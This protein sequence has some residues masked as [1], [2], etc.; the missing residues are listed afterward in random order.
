MITR[1]HIIMGTLGAAAAIA[2]ILTQTAGS[3]RQYQLGGAWIGNNGAGNIWS[4]SHAPLDPEGRTMVGSIRFAT[5]NADFA[6]ILSSLGADTS[7]DHIGQAEMISRD[8]AKWSSVSY[9]LKAGNPPVLQ[10]ILV[11]QGTWKYTSKDTAVLTYTFYAYLP[12]ADADGDGFPDAGSTPAIV[13][14][15]VVDTAQRVPLPCLHK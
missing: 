15:G 2:F 6:A 14:P 7:S 8:T 13:V 12:S 10:G 11:N 9:A 1:K 5:Y 3:N 4:A